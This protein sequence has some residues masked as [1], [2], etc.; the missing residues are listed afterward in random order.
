VNF[1][2]EQ[3]V[4]ALL[5]SFK[6]NLKA[7]NDLRKRKDV[8]RFGCTKVRGWCLTNIMIR[9]SCVPWKPISMHIFR[10]TQTQGLLAE[11][12]QTPLESHQPLTRL[13]RFSFRTKKVVRIVRVSETSTRLVFWRESKIVSTFVWKRSKPFDTRTL[14]SDLWIVSC[15]RSC[16][17][18]VE[19]WVLEASQCRFSRIFRTLFADSSSTRD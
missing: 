17:P 4:Q 8:S 5:Q 10:T 11:S 2:N 3:P 7:S 18:T 16:V 9:F 15:F 1:S 6:P 14:M 13:D 12:F 19:P